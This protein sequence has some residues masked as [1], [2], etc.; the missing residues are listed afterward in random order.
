[1]KKGFLLLV[2]I[3][4][5]SGCSTSYESKFMIDGTIKEKVVFEVKKDEITDC[6]NFDCHN[7]KIKNILKENYYK[8]L[9]KSTSYKYEEL[10]K[11]KIKVTINSKYKNLFDYT[12][13]NPFKNY[14]YKDIS[15]ENDKNIVILKT[16]LYENISVEDKKIDIK[17][18]MPNQIINTNLK[19]QGQVLVMKASGLDS[20]YIKFNKN[21]NYFKLSN[22][23]DFSSISLNLFIILIT[24]FLVLFIVI[25]IFYIKYYSNI[26]N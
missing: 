9:V 2:F 4:L 19:Q 25:I 17:I 15:Y 22:Y 8:L 10:N 12:K 16:K 21:I 20:L 23:I 6:V 11:G 5:L 24:I 26:K 1:M 13:N 14:L 7:S 3:L 18:S